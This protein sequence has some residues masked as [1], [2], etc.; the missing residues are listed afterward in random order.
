MGSQTGRHRWRTGEHPRR[1][2]ARSTLTCCQVIQDLLHTLIKAY[3]AGVKH[4][5]KRWQRGF[6]VTSDCTQSTSEVFSFWSVVCKACAAG[7]SPPQQSFLS[8]ERER[9][10]ERKTREWLRSKTAVVRQ[11][12]SEDYWKERTMLTVILLQ[13]LSIQSVFW[14]VK[15]AVIK[16]EIIFLGFHVRSGGAMAVPVNTFGMQISE[17]K[18]VPS[19][20][21]NRGNALFLRI[22]FW[23]EHFVEV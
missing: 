10:R 2:A 5:F 17:E 7:F 6:P 4:D 14:C 8:R 9:G 12:P 18:Q 19:Q 15:T 13:I 21:L 16:L 22:I 3:P 11:R 1:L 23:E 20:D